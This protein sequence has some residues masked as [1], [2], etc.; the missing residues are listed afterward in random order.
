MRVRRWKMRFSSQGWCRRSRASRTDRRKAHLQRRSEFDPLGCRPSSLPVTACSSRPSSRFCNLDFHSERRNVSH[1]ADFDLL[2]SCWP[3]I[4]LLVSKVEDW[5]KELPVRFR[6][7][8]ERRG[9]IN[10]FPRGMYLFGF[11]YCELALFFRFSN[12]QFGWNLICPIR[13]R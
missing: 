8:A 6:Q 13:K 10:Y 7:A 9:D 5:V 11:P 4:Y 1:R 2:G 3:A 12:L